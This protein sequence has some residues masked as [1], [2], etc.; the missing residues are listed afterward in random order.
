MEAQDQG[1]RMA[2]GFAGRKLSYGWAL[3]L[4]HHVG[5][6][7][8]NQNTAVALMCAESARYC[9]AWH[10]NIVDGKVDSTDHGLYQINDKWHPDFR[11]RDFYSAIDNAMYAFDM[12]SGQWFTAWAAYNSGAHKKFLP[13]VWVVKVLGKWRKKVPYVE[14]ELGPRHTPTMPKTKK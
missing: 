6:R 2:W 12:S 5:F 10:E 8:K 4:T 3:A 13:A 11:E 1:G 7:G 9:G 14:E